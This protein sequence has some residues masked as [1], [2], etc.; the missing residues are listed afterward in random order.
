MGCSTVFPD[1]HRPTRADPS[2]LGMDIL[3]GAIGSLVGSSSRED[4]T[5]VALNVADATVTISKEK[6]GEPSS[7]PPSLSLLLFLFPLCF[8]ST[9]T[10]LGEEKYPSCAA[11]P[12]FFSRFPSHSLSFFHTSSS[13]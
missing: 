6:A 1:I 3:N 9:L 2:A 10:H 5:Q 8:L 7:P 12:L 13:F 11:Y 4:W